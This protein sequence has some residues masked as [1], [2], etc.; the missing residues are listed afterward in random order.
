MR[1]ATALL[2]LIFAGTVL[3]HGQA[4]QTDGNAWLN[5]NTEAAAINVTGIWNGGDWGLVSLTQQ[6]GGRKIIGTADGWDV[7]GVVSGKTVNLIF[8]KKDTVAFSAKL[9]I[10]SS[11]Q[12]T[13][14]YAKG[15][16]PAAA[17]TIPMQLKK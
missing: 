8:W 15:I 11:A 12:L 13:G 2:F 17:K 16:L 4:T 3:L 1:R 7:T 9:A 14:V 10:D 6:A 5:A